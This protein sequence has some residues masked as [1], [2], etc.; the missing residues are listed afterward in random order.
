MTRQAVSRR[1][2][3][4]SDAA[5]ES[6]FV[7][8]YSL[9]GVAQPPP[10]LLDYARVRAEAFALCHP[11]HGKDSLAAIAVRYG[12][13]PAAL[14]RVNNVISEH[15][16]ACRAALYVP[17]PDPAA[18]AAG[19]R[20]AFVHDAAS[21]RRFVVLL[22][23]GE[24]LP[25]GGGRERARGPELTSAAAV[26]RLAGMMERALGISVPEAKFYLGSNGNDLRRAIEACT[27][28]Q[29]W[30]RVMRKAVRRRLAGAAA[31]R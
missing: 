27:N 29:R 2:R 26:E 25:P 13:D 20:A 31:R 4:L 9:A 16:L 14:R 8:R 17:V 11:L 21:K 5:Q 19:K 18:A 12:A 6:S 3:A 1:F 7:A 24:A 15:A 28:D 10:N 23:E 22:G 30:A